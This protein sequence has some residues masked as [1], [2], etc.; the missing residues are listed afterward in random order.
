MIFVNLLFI[1]APALHRVAED[2]MNA[3]VFTNYVFS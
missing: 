1:L 3:V 2:P